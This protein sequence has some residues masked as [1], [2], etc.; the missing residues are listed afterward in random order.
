M[1]IVLGIT[2]WLMVGMIGFGTYYDARWSVDDTIQAIGVWTLW[3]LFLV[4]GIV[5]ILY[6]GL[7]E[8]FTW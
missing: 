2:V 4:K 1:F 7:K 3:P 8:L 6:A 5:H